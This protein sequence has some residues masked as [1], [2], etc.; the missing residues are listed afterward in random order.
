MENLKSIQQWE[1]ILN[2][3]ISILGVLLTIAK[4]LFLTFPGMIVLL[5]CLISIIIVNS[6]DKKGGFTITSIAGGITQTF[7]WFYANIT[8]ILVGLVVIIALSSAF[9]ILKDAART[10]SLYRDVKMLEAA[11][12]N[13]KTERKLLELTV[14]FSI[15]SI[16]PKLDVKLKYFS[17]SPVKDSDLF[18]GESVLSIEG[19][20]L[21]IDF[22]L[23]NFDYSLIEKGTAKNI[24]FPDRIFS[25]TMAAADGERLYSSGSVPLTF[26]LDEKDFVFTG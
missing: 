26:Q 24:A 5:L 19:R 8:A 10:L 3:F 18:S 2:G 25:D 21:Y 15:N 20:K 22:G 12:K 23:I 11:L 13:L 6:R 1:G 9:N 14:K 17:Y 16:K 4:F 7:L